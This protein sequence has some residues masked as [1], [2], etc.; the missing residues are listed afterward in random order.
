MQCD[1]VFCLLVLSGNLIELSFWNY[2]WSDIIIRMIIFTTY[3]ASHLYTYGCFYICNLFHV[4]LYQTCILIFGGD[5]SSKVVSYC[6]SIH[7]GIQFISAQLTIGS[8][9]GGSIYHSMFIWQVLS[10]VMQFIS[11]QLIPG[12]SICHGYTWF[13]LYLQLIL[14]TSV[15]ILLFIYYC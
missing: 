12:G 11:T 5:P 10:S 3:Y 7:T 6:Y 9:V 13:L 14:C 1:T 2:H 15:A 4:L 8:G